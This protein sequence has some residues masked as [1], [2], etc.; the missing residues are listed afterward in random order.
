MYWKSPISILGMF[1][2]GIQIFLKKMG[3]LYANSE[4]P[5]QTLHS[6]ASDLGL[7]CLQVTLLGISR[8]QCVKVS[9][10]LKPLGSYIIPHLYISIYCE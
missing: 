4:D 2:Y 10:P 1:G 5:D 3:K 9:G 8:L 7:H 6:V